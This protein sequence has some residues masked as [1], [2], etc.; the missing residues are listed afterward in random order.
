MID[1]SKIDIHQMV[2]HKVGNKSR[3]E[4]VVVSKEL[5]DIPSDEVK[6]ALLKY[7]VSNFKF[8]TF[9][10]FR[11][12]ADLALNEVYTYA[13][14]MF[15]RPV[16]FH[17]QSIHVLNHLYEQSS[18]PQI[19][20]GELYVVHLNNILYNNFNI[21]AIGLFKSE[22]KDNYLRVDKRAEDD[23]G[24][25][26]E[27]GVNIR[28]LD[29]G[30]IVLNVQAQS[31]YVVGIVD[32]VNKGNQE[33]LYWKEDFLSVKLLED[34]HYITDQYIKMCTD[35]YEN[36]IEPAAE[37]PPEKKEKLQFINSTIDYFA[38]NDQFSEESFVEEV[39]GTPDHM[40]LFKAYKESYEEMNELPPVEQFPISQVALKKV[41]RTMRNHIRTDT[42]VELKLKSE[43]FPY[44]EKGYDEERGMHYYKVYYN[45]EE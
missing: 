45:E 26:L 43:S 17:E 21:D 31:G 28:K 33:A 38:K 37:T 2:I 16:T 12:E 3:D 11:H 27:Q 24:V 23:L 41:K 9:Y 20:A 14:N 30:C 15:Q 42:G 25:Q 19:K 39:I 8:D 6:A 40:P 13:S 34:E 32:M 44:V 10:T 7:F 1:V 36:V 22:N 4:G 35:F 18:H 5:Y 29:K